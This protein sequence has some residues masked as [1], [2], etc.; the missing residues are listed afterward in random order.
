MSDKAGI[1]APV[2]GS[3][4]PTTGNIL[5][6]EDDPDTRSVLACVLSQAG[7]HITAAQDMA[8]ALS[9]AAARKFD[10][11]LLDH[12]LP[13]GSGFDLCRILRESYPN[14]PIVFFSA[15]AYPEDKEEG[16]R[17]GANEYLIKP[18]DIVHV[19]DTA[20]RL[21]SHSKLTA[22]ESALNTAQRYR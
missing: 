18:V 2:D 6:V 10:L 16:I 14:T 11:Y 4:Q 20:T 17:A 21:I 1:G 8:N 22:S 12:V 13:G 3:V 15:S 7:F 5:Y 19:S 9:L